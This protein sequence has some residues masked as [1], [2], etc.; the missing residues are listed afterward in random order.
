MGFK[1]RSSPLMQSFGTDLA[2]QAAAVNA[3][4]QQQLNSGSIATGLPGMVS[5]IQNQIN[6]ADNISSPTN[7]I[8]STQGNSMNDLSRLTAL[9]G[10]ISPRPQTPIN[11]KAFSNQNAITNMYGNSVPGTFNRSVGS[12]LNQTLDPLTG[13]TIDPTMDQSTAG[14][15]PV[16]QGDTAIP[17]PTGVQVPI[18]PTYDINQ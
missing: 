15:N 11:P 17:P 6:R 3:Q 4:Q 8:V 9:K 10:S 18:T 16:V 1:Q 14:I 12:P 7:P 13:Q 2:T 5:G